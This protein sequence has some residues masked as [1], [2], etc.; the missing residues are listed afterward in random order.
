V[1]M[2]KMKEAKKTFMEG[3]RFYSEW[4]LERTMETAEK[5]IQDREALQQASKGEKIDPSPRRGEGRKGGASS[6]K[7]VASRTL[8]YGSGR[9]KRSTKETRRKSG[10][11]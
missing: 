9:E 6:V 10:N 5:S 8:K 4:D 7:A 11:Q 3:F 2:L 1:T